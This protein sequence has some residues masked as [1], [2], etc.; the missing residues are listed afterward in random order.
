MAEMFGISRNGFSAAMIGLFGSNTPFTGAGRKKMSPLWKEF[1]RG[2]ISASA[3]PT[4]A[5]V[6]SP[7]ED[8]ESAESETE[9][10]KQM[11]SLKSSAELCIKSGSLRFAGTPEAVFAKA[12]LAMNPMEAYEVEIRFRRT[13]A[14][15]EEANAAE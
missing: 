5:T 7:T 1:I 14:Q 12:I 6:N 15:S 4:P 2:D 13:T 10:V 3:E 8:N 9:R 11:P